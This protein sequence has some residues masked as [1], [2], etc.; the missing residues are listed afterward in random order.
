MRSRRV[1]ILL[2]S[3]A[4]VALA[5]I[6]ATQ[7]VVRLRVEAREAQRDVACR[8]ATRRLYDAIRPY[9][10]QDRRSVEAVFNARRPFA[11]TPVGPRETMAVV[12]DADDPSLNASVRV[13][14]TD[15]R[16]TGSGTSSPM[17]RVSLPLPVGWAI[18]E[19]ARDRSATALPVAWLASMLAWP[20]ARRRLA[21]RDGFGAAALIGV[22][23]LACGIAH[24]TWYGGGPVHPLNR[25]DLWAWPL[26]AIAASAA[27][28]R[29]ARP[30]APLVGVC[31]ACGYDLTAN[32]SGVCPECGVPR[33]V[34]IA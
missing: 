7:N 3:L 30:A 27:A 12:V 13:Y 21:P 22:A 17:P 26:L 24:P 29:I 10:G 8:T 6:K 2:A 14:F 4:I 34:D 5:A 18:G 31:A 11:V 33:P 1:V 16:L 28:L 20:L 9:Y 23:W 19:S 32:V 25:A 15:D